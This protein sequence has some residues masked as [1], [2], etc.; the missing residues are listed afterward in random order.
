METVTLPKTKYEAIIRQQKELMR[1]IKDLSIKLET[2]SSLEKFEEIT[3][4]GRQ[5]A[6]KRGIKPSDVLVND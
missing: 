1:K 5:F 3:K 6:K 4:W 2:L